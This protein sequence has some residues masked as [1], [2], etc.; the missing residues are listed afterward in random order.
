MYYINIS[1]HFFQYKPLNCFHENGFPL[2][3]HL[4]VSKKNADIEYI[5]SEEKKS[6]L[7]CKSK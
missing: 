4:G 7:H 5:N 6:I 2:K 1:K 3:S